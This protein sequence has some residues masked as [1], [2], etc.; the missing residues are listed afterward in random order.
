MKHKKLFAVITM[1]SVIITIILLVYFHDYFSL[2]T[3]SNISSQEFDIISA[4]YN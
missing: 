4:D 1:V 3:K 2:K